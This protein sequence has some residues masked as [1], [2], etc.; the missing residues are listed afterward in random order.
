MKEPE[1]IYAGKAS[2]KKQTVSCVL[3]KKWDLENLEMPFQMNGTA[4]PRSRKRLEPGLSKDVP[5]RRIVLAMGS[6]WVQ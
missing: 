2:Q 4:W 6:G 3:E 1:L 5:L